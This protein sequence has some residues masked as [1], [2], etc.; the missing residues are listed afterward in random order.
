MSWNTDTILEEDDNGFQG[1]SH[2]QLVQ[3]Y[4]IHELDNNMIS[5]RASSKQQVIILLLIFLDMN[6]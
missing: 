4:A 3:R 1:A 6:K 5:L 2:L